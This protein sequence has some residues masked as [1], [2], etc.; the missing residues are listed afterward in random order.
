MENHQKVARFSLQYYRQMKER[1]E[2]QWSE[3]VEL[4]L[5]TSSPKRDE[6]LKQLHHAFTLILSADYQM[7]K[8]L[9]HWGQSA[10]PSSTYYLRTKGIV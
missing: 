9:P 3:I 1:C 8:L 2:K 5:A 7:S 6:K 10:Q 4:E